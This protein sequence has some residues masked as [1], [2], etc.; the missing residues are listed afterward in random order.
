MPL[1]LLVVVGMLVGAAVATGWVGFGSAAEGPAAVASDGLPLA[2]DGWD[3]VGWPVDDRRP[4]TA[5][6]VRISTTRCGDE[7]R[8]SGFVVGGRVLTNRHVI[9]GARSIVVTTAD[10][11]AHRVRAI[12]ASDRVD[13]ASLTADGVG[14][15]L[16]LADEDAAVDAGGLTLAGFPGGHDLS[17][18]SARVAGTLRGLGFPDPDR[19]L[20]L[21]VRVV[22][23]ESGSAL[24]DAD[25]RVVALLYARAV[26]DGNGLAVAGSQLR[27]TLSDL[28]PVEFA[29][30]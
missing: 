10:G 9:D 19:A 8:G 22:P 20:H 13:V 11:E 29:R 1:A 26:V 18:R 6:L 27:A 17:V 3:R 12:D 28:G 23:G 14:D 15:G 16:D 30:C 24:I 2:D 5:S 25:G 7:I 21:D 4:W